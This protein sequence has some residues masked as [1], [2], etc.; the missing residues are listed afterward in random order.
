[1]WELL[2]SPLVWIFIIILGIILLVIVDSI[3]T[4]KR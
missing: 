2:A 4:G 1:M 3:L